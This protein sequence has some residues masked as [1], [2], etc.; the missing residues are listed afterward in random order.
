MI[1]YRVAQT[2]QAQFVTPTIIEE[3]GVTA[4]A[5]EEEGRPKRRDA[6]KWFRWMSRNKLIT[7]WEG[8][9]KSVRNRFGPCK[10][11]DPQGA[12]SKLLQLGTVAQYQ[13]DFEKLMNRI[14]EIPENLLI[15]F[16]IPGLKPSLQQELL[17]SKPTTLGCHSR[18][19]R[20]FGERGYLHLKFISGVRESMISPVVGTI[21]TGNIHVGIDNG[22]T[23]TFVQPGVVERMKLVV[24][25]TKPF[26]VYIRSGETLLCENICSK[27][28]LKMQ[29][30]SMEVD[31]YVLPMKGPDVVLGIQ[32]LQKLG[33]VTHSYAQQ[34]MEFTLEGDAHAA[35]RC[36][37]SHEADQF[38]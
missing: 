12:L 30:L 6:V 19:R 17:V 32:W 21:S 11:E 9:L 16:C 24:T 31:L 10:Y 3:E 7:D 25:S 38:A 2:N 33:K 1:S 37:T 14:T 5:V 34:T 27:V 4:F 13:S 15:S 36:V 28:V 22:S 20:G 8:F 26:K 35:R 23:R 29:G 18:S